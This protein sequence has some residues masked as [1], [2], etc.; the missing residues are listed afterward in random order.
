[1]TGLISDPSEQNQF[2]YQ[3]C[4]FCVFLFAA[5]IADDGRVKIH[6]DGWNS[7][8]YDYYTD[9]S[10]NDLHPVGWCSKNMHKYRQL[11]QSLQAPKGR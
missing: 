5:D 9:F 8:S 4:M 1:M 7:G 6:F 2:P 10:S 3:V 11:N